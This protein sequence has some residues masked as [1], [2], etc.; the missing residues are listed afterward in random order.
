MKTL[1]CSVTCA[2]NRAA[3]KIATAVVEKR[4]AACANIVP[5]IE[6]IYRWRGKIENGT[7]VLLL[8]KTRK[9]LKGKLSAELK[10]LHS[11]E[12]PV[13]EFF[14]ADTGKDVASGIK[15]ETGKRR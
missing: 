14:E 3:R 1:I 15:E 11:Y 13:V 4:L 8:L 10:K 12:P 5:G 6:S 7:E 9:E 2:N